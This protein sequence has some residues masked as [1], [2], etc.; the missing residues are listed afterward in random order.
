MDSLFDHPESYVEGNDPT[1]PGCLGLSGGD[2]RGWTHE[3]RLPKQVAVRSSHLQAVFAQRDLPTNDPQIADL[4]E[5]CVM[6]DVDRVPYDGPKD[7]DFETLKRECISYMQK[8]LY[9]N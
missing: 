2:N 9:L 6:E 4:F 5:W 1:I 3:V 8:K 7:G